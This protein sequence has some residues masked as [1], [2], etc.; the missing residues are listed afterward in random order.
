MTRRHYV[1]IAKVI[2]DSTA[3]DNHSSRIQLAREVADMLGEPGM[4]K[5]FDRDLFIAYATSDLV[6]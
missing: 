2:R 3:F 4:A 1:A 5:N 6:E